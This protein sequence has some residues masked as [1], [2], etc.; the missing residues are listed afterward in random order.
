MPFGAFLSELPGL[1]QKLKVPKW[2]CRSTLAS[3]CN[4][5][6]FFAIFGPA[7]GQIFGKTVR[8]TRAEKKNIFHPSSQAPGPG[9]GLVPPGPRPGP[10][11]RR[12]ENLNK[13]LEK[14]EKIV[15]QNVKNIGKIAFWGLSL[16]TSRF[17][18]KVKSSK[19]GLS[20]DPRQFL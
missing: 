3:F 6:P 14:F 10:L 20:I 12:M 18:P 4:G 13:R 16:G 5:P 11:R 9:P 17:E 7:R 1:N 19:M 15:K 2:V 8:K